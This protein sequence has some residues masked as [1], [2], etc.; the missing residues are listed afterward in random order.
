MWSKAK[1]PETTLPALSQGQ[2]RPRPL[3]KGQGAGPGDIEKILPVAGLTKAGDQSH[4]EKVAP[5][6]Y[7]FNQSCLLPEQCDLLR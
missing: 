6:A 4:T 5:E 7:C 3:E 2:V 1:G